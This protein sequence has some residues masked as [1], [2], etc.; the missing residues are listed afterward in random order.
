MICAL[1]CASGVNLVVDQVLAVLILEYSP[2]S[3]G[4]LSSLL[5]VIG[6]DLGLNS[7]QFLQRFFKPPR[8][9]FGILL[10]L[11]CA[12]NP[13]QVV[14]CFSFVAT[15]RYVVTVEFRVRQAVV[16]PGQ[17][18]FPLDPSAS[19]LIAKLFILLPGPGHL[20]Y[21]VTMPGRYLGKVFVRGEFAV[22][23]VDE[24]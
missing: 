7:S 12:A 3:L 19:N 8:A 21:K 10:G 23:N 20:T 1:V 17:D 18:M 13:V 15:L 9:S 5:E 2:N 4:N 11:L 24:I 22:R 14:T 6:V 16:S